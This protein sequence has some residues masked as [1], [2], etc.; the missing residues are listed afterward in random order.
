MKTWRRAFDAALVS[1]TAASVAS[2]AALMASGAREAGSVAAPTNAISHWLW[3]DRAMRVDGVDVPHTVAGFAIHEGA[4]VFWA[5]LYEKFVADP[6]ERR[7]VPRV[8]ADAGLV[9]AVACFVDYRLTPR[10]LQPGFEQRLS[11]PAL[12]AVYAAFGAGL[13]AATLARRR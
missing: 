7:S 11:R 4:S 6:A 10:R 9:A 12:L 13:A 3:G 2:T 1:G 5:T 8:L